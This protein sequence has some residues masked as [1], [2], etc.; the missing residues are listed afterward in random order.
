M[1]WFSEKWS[2]LKSKKR[3]ERENERKFFSNERKLKKGER[4]KR[5]CRK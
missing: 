4:N 5:T 3:A 1:E 2:G